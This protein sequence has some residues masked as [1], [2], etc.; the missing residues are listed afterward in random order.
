[1]LK[2]FIFKYDFFK[3]IQSG[4]YLDFIIKKISETF[5]KNYFIYSSHYFGEKYVIEY[6]TKKIIESWVFN[7]NKNFFFFSLFNSIFFIQLLT[8]I[9]FYFSIF[10]FL[11]F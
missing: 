6:I 8:T 2:L 11:Y 5:V 1:M 9:F 4:F 7:S 10:L 3:F